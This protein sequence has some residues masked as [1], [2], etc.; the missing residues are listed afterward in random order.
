MHG[1]SDDAIEPDLPAAEVSGGRRSGPAGPTRRGLLAALGGLGGAA[2]LAACTD[3][4]GNALTDPTT[5]TAGRRTTT[6]VEP[7]DAPPLPGVDAEPFTLGVASGDPDA[8]SV[9]LW[10]R[11]AP[12]PT[13]AAGGMPGD[14]AE[15]VW[16]VAEDEGFDRLVA[17]GTAPAPG[18]YAHSVHAVADGLAPD[19]WY[20]YRFR[21]G[22]WTSPAGRTRTAPRPGADV[23]RLVM[24]T[25]SCQDWEAGYYVAHRALAAE[26]DLDLV[27]WLGDYIYEG[28]PGDAGV[29][30]HSSPEITDLD[31]YRVRYAQ[32]KADQDLQA[33]HARA[34]WLVIWDDHEVENNYAGLVPQDP[35]EAATFPQRRADAYQAWWE[36]Q[37]VRMDPPEGPDLPIHRDL[38]WGTLAHLFAL[39]TRQERADQVC[40]LF[41]GVDAG[42]VCDDLDDP[43]QTI[44][45]ADQERWL[46][47]G[48]AEGDTRWNVIANQ[49][50]VAPVPVVG[51]DIDAAA[52][53]DAASA[54]GVE[55][56]P[57]LDG[58]RGVLADQ[59]DGYPAQRQRLLD[60]MASAPAP[61]V[62]LTGDIHASGATPLRADPADPSSEVVAAEFVGT[63]ISSDNGQFSGLFDAIYGPAFEYYQSSRRGY[64]RVE[65]TPETTTAAYV[66]VD[67][68]RDPESP[69]RVEATFDFDRDRTF[70]TA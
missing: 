52:L 55:E 15:V 66:V 69:T 17:T 35:A 3:D 10:T 61:T 46:L 43:A 5:T 16:E 40:A 14:D 39:D 21:A 9:V 8:T 20:H 67:D 56:I 33:A 48:L 30:R 42:P 51:D 19:T 44:I 36:H 64:V 38:R 65:V 60:A 50:V 62:V 24:A 68:A 27:L 29:R 23:D 45:G 47:D 58:L 57:P 49:V 2:V 1:P 12:V 32:Y 34:P 53:A 22:E 13:E 54:L 26:D 18:R 70:A 37:P 7:L 6:V 4:G 41:P 25:G 63:S 28:G 59:W 31:A 11:L